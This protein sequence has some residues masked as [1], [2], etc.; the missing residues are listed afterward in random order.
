MRQHDLPG[1][2]AEKVIDQSVLLEK[3]GGFGD[4]E[5]SGKEESYPLPEEK[6]V[7]PDQ[8]QEKLMIAEQ[9][10]LPYSPSEKALKM[11]RVEYQVVLSALGKAGIPEPVI[12]REF[13][14]Q[15]GQVE[16]EAEFVWSEE[17]V[18]F[19]TP[20]Q[21]DYRDAIRKYGFKVWVLPETG[22]ETV[23]YLNVWQR[24]TRDTAGREV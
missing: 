14:G 8:N 10:F 5:S 3:H 15:D 9:K 17:K 21:G 24:L 20:E 2:L 6:L 19:L 13:T 22:L 18:C 11:V 12:G 7:D 1:E 23:D 4:G 16:A